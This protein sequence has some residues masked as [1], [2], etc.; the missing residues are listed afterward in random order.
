MIYLLA[1]IIVA[2]AFEQVIL[3]VV[4]IDP[5]NASDANGAFNFRA[6]CVAADIGFAQS[7]VFSTFARS[8]IHLGSPPTVPEQI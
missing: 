3:P 2:V 1:R 6:F 5:V 4:G 8:T 7:L